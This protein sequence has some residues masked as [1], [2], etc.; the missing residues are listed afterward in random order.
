VTARVLTGPRRDDTGF[1]LLELMVALILLSIG[2]FAVANLFPAGMH[3]QVQDRM[4]AEAGG[5]AQSEIERLSGLA[6]TDTQLDPGRH[7]ASG[8]TPCGTNGH[9]SRSYTVATLAAPLADVKKVSV[10]VSWSGAN[11]REVTIATYVRS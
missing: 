4:Q 5:L 3:G 11:G 7:P 1:T 6:W 9:W 2:V 8:D 10:T